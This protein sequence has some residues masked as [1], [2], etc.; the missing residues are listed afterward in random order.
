MC[1]QRTCGA[2][3]QDA[4]LFWRSGLHLVR[5]VNEDLNFS[6]VVTNG[7]SLIFWCLDSGPG[8]WFVTVRAGP[9]HKWEE[10]GTVPSTCET[11]HEKRKSWARQLFSSLSFKHRIHPCVLSWAGAEFSLEKTLSFHWLWMGWGWLCDQALVQAAGWLAPSCF[12]CGCATE[13]IQL[14]LQGPPDYPQGW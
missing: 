12:Q 5:A 13:M 1:C 8:V 6:G 4:D 3:R 10:R 14:L 9:E 11:S 7:F 2:K